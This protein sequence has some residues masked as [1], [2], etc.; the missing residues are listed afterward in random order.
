L[1]PNYFPP[2]SSTNQDQTPE[3]EPENH[4]ACLP[5]LLSLG[6]DIHARNNAGEGLLHYAARIDMGDVV[7]VRDREQ[8]EEVVDCFRCLMEMGLDP[9]MEDNEG[10][11]PLDVAA[12]CE[13]KGV[14]KLFEREDV[15]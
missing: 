7:V 9:R 14:L 8:E 12:A 13:N 4:R 1:P 3:P 2:S 6:F 10:K 15:E 11:T 5:L